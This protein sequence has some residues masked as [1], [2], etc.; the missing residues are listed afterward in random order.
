MANRRSQRKFVA[1]LAGVV[2]YLLSFYY[3]LFV[4]M[5]SQRAWAQTVGN[6]NSTVYLPVVSRQEPPTPTPSPTS[7]P[8]PTPSPTPSIYS[9]AWAGT[10]AKSRPITMTVSQDS[11]QLLNFMLEE[12][13]DGIFCVSPVLVVDETPVA[14]TNGEFSGV[15]KKGSVAKLT[16]SGKFVS[17]TAASGSYTL[18][19]WPSD[20]G[21]TSS[22][23]TWTANVVVE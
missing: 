6:T 22:Q 13:R 2:V 19:K 21:W 4:D 11:T 5:S 14:I 20:C 10:T 12:K 3:F 23:G 17:P 9:G 15:Y 1:M 7:T 8:V 16:F 18:Y